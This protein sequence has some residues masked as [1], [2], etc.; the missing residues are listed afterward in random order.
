MSGTDVR[1]GK[2]P[3]VTVLLATLFNSLIK[4][5]ASPHCLNS[6]WKVSFSC[7]GPP[8]TFT[9]FWHCTAF[10]HWTALLYLRRPSSRYRPNHIKHHAV[11][12]KFFLSAF[13]SESSFSLS[14]RKY[15]KLI[16]F[17]LLIFQFDITYPPFLL[18][19]W[20]STWCSL[21]KW[22]VINRYEP[23][24]RALHNI[25]LPFGV[26]SSEFFLRLTESLPV[27]LGIG[28]PFGAHDQILSFSSF[29]VWQLLYSSFY[30]ILSDEKTVLYFSVRTLT[31]Q[32]INDQ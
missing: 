26:Q 24:T 11:Q 2:L 12:F 28:P 3:M 17:S 6:G 29:F 22:V 23:K 32:V 30:G 7:C 8:G 14:Y 19:V 4:R 9:A 16:I 20:T 15:F 18:H 13:P 25:P 1:F 5:S 27:R 10:W 31:G 21:I